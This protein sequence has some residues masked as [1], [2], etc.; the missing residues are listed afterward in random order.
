MGW[1]RRL[2]L[3]FL[4]IE[5]MFSDFSREREEMAALS[6]QLSDDSMIN[7]RAEGLL[8]GLVRD[9]EPV[10]KKNKV[11]KDEMRK[12]CGELEARIEKLEEAMN[13]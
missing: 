1:L 11:I 2:L 9:V 10:I 8:R 3:R 5:Q 7:N 12:R 13:G 4:G 6:Q